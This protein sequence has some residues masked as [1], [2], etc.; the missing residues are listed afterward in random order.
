MS[1]PGQTSHLGVTQLALTCLRLQGEYANAFG[2]G[3]G[4]G[5]GNL[6]RRCR[7]ALP[8]AVEM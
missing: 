4:Y 1:L 6:D 7:A 3:T 2:A 8:A 5:I